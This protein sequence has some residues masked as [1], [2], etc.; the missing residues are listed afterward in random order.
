IAYVDV[1]CFA[2]WDY[3]ISG[4]DN[5][6]TFPASGYIWD[7]DVTSHELGH[8]F[9]SPHTHSCDW[10]PAID[11]CYTAEGRCFSTP[12]PRSGSIMSY[13]H[14][15][16]YGKYTAFHPRVRTQIRTA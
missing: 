10:A 16:Q 14:L 8:N 13:C 5:N 11:S 4:L 3:G 15:T 6:I 9:S 1:L 12:V 2:N 7:T